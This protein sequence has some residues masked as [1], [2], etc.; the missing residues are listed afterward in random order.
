MIKKIILTIGATA[1]MSSS[2]FANNL[3]ACTGCHGKTFE[4]K[5]LGKSL[6]V[7]NM[8]LSDIKTS[9]SGYKDGSYGKKMKG[10]MITQLKKYEDTDSLAINVFEGSGNSIK[11]KGEPKDL[12]FIIR[13]KDFKAELE[14]ISECVESANSSLELNQCTKQLSICSS[15]ITEKA[16]TPDFCIH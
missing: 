10:I 12:M 8:S 1:L 14:K 13:K 3:S 6:I 16:K 9:L 11:K 15:Q 2:L 7:K 4:K 5:A